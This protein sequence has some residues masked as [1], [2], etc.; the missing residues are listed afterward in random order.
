MIWI[1]L[2]VPPFMEISICRTQVDT[3]FDIGAKRCGDRTMNISYPE[4]DRQLGTPETAD[5][6]NF[7]LWRKTM[8]NIHHGFGVSGLLSLLGKQTNRSSQNI[9]KQDLL[10][11][12]LI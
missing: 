7:I 10:T 6:I 1:D 3:D 5:S 11:E 9:P 12:G 8:E 4:N 2:G